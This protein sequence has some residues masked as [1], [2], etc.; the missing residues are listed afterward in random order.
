[1]LPTLSGGDFVVATRL[2]HVIAKGDLLVVNHPCFGRIIKRVK[3]FSADHG[4]LL[5]SD[6]NEGMSSE[7]LGWIDKQ[8]IQAKVLFSIKQ[9]N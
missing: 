1:M 2:Y 6:H 4:I 5:N 9:P 3:A 7:Q 8:D